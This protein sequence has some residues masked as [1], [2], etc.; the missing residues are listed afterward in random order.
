MEYKKLIKNILLLFNKNFFSRM[1]SALVFV[2]LF[3]LSLYNGGITLFIFFLIILTFIIY[4]LNNLYIK[5]NKRILTGIYSI[6][7]VLTVTLFPIFYLSNNSSFASFMYI[8]LSIWTFDT[9][10][11]FGGNIFKGKKIFPHISSGKT[12]SGL[13]TGFSTLIIANII[14]FILMPIDSLFYLLALAIILGILSFVGDAI[15]SILKRASKIKDSGKLMPGHG[16]LL[17]R[18]DSFILVFFFIIFSNLF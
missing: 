11:F 5:S 15:V 18:F 14:F 3:I 10:S 6:I 16:G 8:I 1:I 2:P 13:I 4:E 17:D 12:Y 9:F 7:S